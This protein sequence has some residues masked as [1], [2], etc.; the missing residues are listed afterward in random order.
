MASIRR[1]AARL[2]AKVRTRP[3]TAQTTPI[4]GIKRRYGRMSV[5]AERRFNASLYASAR[6]RSTRRRSR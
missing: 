1:R 3:T 2:G 6:N 4:Y 5:G